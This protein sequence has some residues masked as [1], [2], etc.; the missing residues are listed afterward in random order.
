MRSCDHGSC[1]CSKPACS[2][3]VSRI[4]ERTA[5]S[6]RRLLRVNISASRIEAEILAKAWDPMDKCLWTKEP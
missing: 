2:R 6:V 1:G 5:E 4:E 3:W